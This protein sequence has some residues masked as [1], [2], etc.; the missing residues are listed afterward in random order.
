MPVLSAVLTLPDPAAALTALAS[1]PE[2]TIGPPKGVR[3]PVVLSTD[4]RQADKALWSWVQ[5]LPGVIHVELV[6]VDFSDLH[7]EGT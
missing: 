1:K 5:A 2:V 4:S 3:Y 6:F 7:E